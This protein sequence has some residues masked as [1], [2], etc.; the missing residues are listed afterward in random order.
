MPRLAQN[1]MHILQYVSANDSL[2]YHIALRAIVINLNATTTSY[3]LT[4]R[5]GCIIHS[6]ANECRPS[7]HREFRVYQT[8]PTDGSA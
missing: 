8:L 4:Y 7:T 2:T 1:R 3:R 6:Y 5:I